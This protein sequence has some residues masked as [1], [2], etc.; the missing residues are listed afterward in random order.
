MD[1]FH[2][3]C[4]HFVS[5]KTF[6]YCGRGLFSLP[7]KKERKSVM[8]VKQLRMLS[9]AVTIIIVLACTFLID[10]FMLRFYFIFLGV[11]GYNV[12]IGRTIRKMMIEE[13]EGRPQE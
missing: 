10:S 9:F 5:S 3:L 13:Q 7:M 12:V 11:M 2:R 1:R 8:N 4:W 6:A